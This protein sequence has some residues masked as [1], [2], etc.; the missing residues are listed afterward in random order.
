MNYNGVTQSAVLWLREQ[1]ITGGLPAGSKIN[2]TAIAETIGISRPPLREALRR[3]ESEYLV[4][5][6]PRK[7]SFV[8]AMSVEDCSQIY[9]VREILECTAMDLA[10]PRGP[11]IIALIWKA[12][13]VAEEKDCT[14]VSGARQMM[15]CFNSMSAFHRELI[16]CSGNAWV[17]QCYNG[18]YSSLARYQVMYLY[19]PGSRNASQEDHYSIMSCLENGELEKAK[20]KMIDHLSI[21]KNRI[22]A[23]IQSENS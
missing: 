15:E 20:T 5:S 7:G 12:L 14:F 4:F 3:L 16:N 11:D 21:T 10:I 22:I 8:T 13:R 17:K 2:E 6:K 19:I 9:R 18:L 1:I 23:A